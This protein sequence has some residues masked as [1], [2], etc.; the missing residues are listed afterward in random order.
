MN[1]KSREIQRRR[2]RLRFVAA[3]KKLWEVSDIVEMLEQW[4]LA[5][6]KLEYQFVARQYK[7]GTG[8]S[9]RSGSQAW[10]LN[11]R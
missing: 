10:L 11:Q 1:K 9:V 3:S 6:F 7:I 4:G 5:N 2:S 8:H